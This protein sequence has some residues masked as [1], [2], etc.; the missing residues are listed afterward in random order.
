MDCCEAGLACGY[1][2]SEAARRTKAIGSMTEIRLREL[3]DLG[4]DLQYTRCEL[5]IRYYYE[6][7]RADA[8]DG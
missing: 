3:Y 4:K 6:S 2:R 7:S 8:K 5:V 1:L